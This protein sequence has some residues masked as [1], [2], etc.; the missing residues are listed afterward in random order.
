MREE[1]GEAIAEPPVFF[2]FFSPHSKLA[3]WLLDGKHL[4]ANG[5]GPRTVREPC[6]A[7]V[8]GGW[9]FKLWC[10]FN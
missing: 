5:E 2:F 6:S 9:R 8:C 7:L 3:C 1:K 10:L 4:G